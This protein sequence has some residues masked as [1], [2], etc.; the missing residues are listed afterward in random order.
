MQKFIKR[1]ILVIILILFSGITLVSAQGEIQFWEDFEEGASSWDLEPGWMVIQVGE[2][3]LLQGEGH[4]WARLDQDF[5]G[6]FQLSFRTKL[7]QGRLHLVTHLNNQGRYYTGIGSGDTSLSKQYWPDSFQ[8]N[9]ANQGISLPKNT[10]VDVKMISKGDTLRLYINGQEQ[11]MFTDPEKFDGGKLAFETLEESL[12]QVDDL[13]ITYQGESHQEAATPQEQPQAEIK[14]GASSDT[15][16]RTGGPLGGLGYDVRMHPENPDKMYV[17]DAYAGVF[18]SDDGGK[19]WYPSNQG[20]IDRSGESQDAIPVFC[21]T[22]DP[23][24][25]EIIW[26]GTQFSGGLFKSLDGGKSW[27]QKTSGITFRD[28][29]TFRGITIDPVD[30]NIVYTAG[31]ISSW[32]W[33]GV[34]RLGREFDLTKGVVYKSVDGGEHWQEIWRGDN[35]ARYIW[36]NPQDNQT[37]YVSTGIFDREAANSDPESGYPGGVGIIKSTDG[38][39]SW[40]EINNG[41]SNLYVGS[42]FMHPENPEILLAGTGNNQYFENNGVYITLDGGE[43]WKRVN[44]GESINVTSVEFSLTNPRIAYAGGEA[45]IMRSEDG[46]QTWKF[47]NP[48]TYGWGPPGIRGGFPIDFQIDP[49]DPNRIFANNYGG[50]NFL[51]EDAGKTWSVAST[52]YTG[53]Q[54]RDLNI[55]P[56]YPGVVFAAA[57]SGIF[58]SHNGGTSWTGLG[59]DPY[60]VLEWNAIAVDPTDN[61]VL[62]ASTNWW[63]LLLYSTDKGRS[64]EKVLELNGNHGVRT[65]VFSPSNPD[66]VYAGTGGFFSAGSFDPNTAGQGI[67]RSEDGGKNWDQITGGEYKDAHVADISISPGD[68]QYLFAATT[69]YGII[70]TRDGGETWEQLNQ[71]IMMRQGARSV[72]VHPENPDIV[73]AGIAFGGIYRSEDAGESWSHSSAGLNPEANITDIVIDPSNPDIVYASDSFSGVYRSS[74]GGKVWRA[75]SEGLR[76]RAVYVLALSRDGSHLYAGTDGEGVFRRD[77]EGTPPQGLEAEIE[78]VEE[79]TIE[80]H[81]AQEETLESPSVGPGE[82]SPGR[83]ICPGSY[84][85]LMALLAGYPLWIKRKSKNLVG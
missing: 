2:N 23:H 16:I 81:E 6:D 72:A 7:I 52:G 31:E 29:L 51:S 11:W 24:N 58:L 27:S 26:A 84:L 41:L 76:M 82:G 19:N 1:L 38:G 12:V 35:L 47:I 79:S 4:F 28:G 42:L 80:E 25:P 37:L 20:I 59:A 48:D 18:I 61:S 69:N 3:S 78:P 70:R 30:P 33:A 74:D 71:G 8:H 77:L 73:L 5:P 40:K 68:H 66:W 55:D 85:P 83:Q 15:W 46:G 39:Q 62:L 56:N 67:F 9:L 53:A 49:R 63:Q 10:W 44:S 32:V 17:T 13:T 50:G 60:N 45:N 22:I 64:W 65:V 54:I 34:E 21:L 57:R 14:S 36:V 75:F 43:S